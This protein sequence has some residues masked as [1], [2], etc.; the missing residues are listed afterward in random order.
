MLKQGAEDILHTYCARYPAI[1][2]I[3][4]QLRRAVQLL[5]DCFAQGGALLV[6]GNG[7][8]CADADHIV[9]ELVK[10]FRLKRPLVEPLVEALRKQG[11]QGDELCQHL[12]DGL[13]AINL[14]AHA[15]L[16]TAVANDIGGAYIFAQQVAVYG[17]QGDILL[18]IST[19]GNAEDV[20]HAGAVA[21]AKGMTTIGLTGRGGG[22]MK[23]Q[24]DLILHG[25]A[26][27]TEDIQDL[28][29]A[30]YHALCACVEYQCWGD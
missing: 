16:M 19:S 28:H 6:C 24:F 2:E 22:R 21:K 7:G 8:S 11:V 25:M 5:Q 26:D 15:A 13:P 9:G 18:A 29:S 27:S 10:A 30:I 4:S 20:L 3:E 23:R 1:A 14:G 17:R 12:Q